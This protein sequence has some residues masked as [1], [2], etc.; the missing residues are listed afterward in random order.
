MQRNRQQSDLE[1]Y[2]TKRDFTVTPEPAPALRHRAGPLLFVIHEHAARRLHYDLR[3]ELDGVLKSWAVPN[4]LLLQPGEKHLAVPTE[5][6]PLDYGNFEG[7]IP[8]KQYGA[9]KVIV[10]DCG[11]YSPDA[12]KLYSFHDREQAQ[13]RIRK[14]LS[15]GK[16][17]ITFAGAK[18]K[19]SYAL[20]RTAKGWLLIK[21]DDGITAIATELDRSP[22]SAETVGTV[23]RTVPRLPLDRMVPG[24]PREQMPQKIAVMTAQ[25]HTVNEP[26]TDPAWMYEPKLDGYRATVYLDKGQVTILSR[27]GNDYTQYFPELVS[28]LARQPVQPLVL[29]GEII[30]FEEGRPS[31]SALQNRFKPG[32]LRD[33]SRPCVFYGFDVLHAAGVNTRGVA[34]VD[35]RRFLKQCVTPGSAV[36]IVHTDT[37]GVALYRAAVATGL[38][39]IMAKERSGVYMAGIRSP[40]WLKIKRLKSGEFVIVGYT[41]MKRLLSSLLLGYWDSGHLKYAGRVGTGFSDDTID[42]LLS[43]LREAKKPTVK[44][45]A[46]KGLATKEL[47]AATWVEPN[48]VAEVSYYE[49]TKEDRLRHPVFL[50]LRDDIDPASVSAP[51]SANAM[52]LAASVPVHHDIGS[53]VKQLDKLANKGTLLVGSH[54]VALT[55]L[56]KILWPAHKRHKPLTKRDLLRYLVTASPLLLPYLRN[57][58]LTLIRMPDGIAG[59][60]FFQ[61]HLDQALPSFMRTLVV[62]SKGR[63]AGKPLILCNDLAS[64]IWLGNLGTLEFHVWHSSSRAISDQIDEAALAEFDKPDYLAFDLDPFVYSGKEAPGEEPAYNA[65]AFNLC[66]KVA[67]W[68]KEV[69]DALGLRSFVK[70]TGKT[71]LHVYV[72]IRKTLGFDESKRVCEI[73]GRHVVA[74]HPDEVTMEWSIPKRTGKIFIDHNM[75]GRG[76]TLLAAYSPRAQPGA[77]FSMP[78]AWEELKDIDP[79]AFRIAKN[80]E[81]LIDPWHGFLG[82]EQ[83]IEQAVG[84]VS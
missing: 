82:L 63:D 8:P 54:K 49:V 75:N 24:E 5:D 42:L 21:H 70:T 30:A 22:L 23:S 26:F 6:H 40:A 37:D 83:N 72:P 41:K 84:S 44:E 47:A 15:D 39:G 17:S 27:G 57:R 76:R 64:L 1:H 67:Y 35:R 65:R 59:E 10:W 74:A 12:G 71:G 66:V 25:T 58:P 73:I 46:V 50:R 3:L 56:D 52:G 13:A 4:G 19:G 11:L 60:A 68:V 29:D 51:S 53:I 48:L 34:Y 20:I 33:R 7:V 62:P 28:E 69:L 55:Q 38:E 80:R 78:V 32:P 43:R 2:A 45:P 36:Q 79:S 14:E 16:L 81:G 18:L 61:K 77:T 31:F 9:G